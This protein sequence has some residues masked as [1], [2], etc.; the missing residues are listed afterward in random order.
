MPGVCSGWQSQHIASASWT[1]RR[2]GLLSSVCFIFHT[3]TPWAPGLGAPCA[4]FLA[5][6][7]LNLLLEL[8]ARRLGVLLNRT[9]AKLTT[10]PTGKLDTWLREVV[11]WQHQSPRFRPQMTAKNA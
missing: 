8:V 6:C 2:C 11:L 7:A 9:L 1:W 5:K 3:L 4:V 10:P